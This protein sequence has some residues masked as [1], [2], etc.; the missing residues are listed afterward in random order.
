MLVVA[1]E[2]VVRL[3]VPLAEPHG[4]RNPVS[5]ISAADDTRS[6]KETPRSTRFARIMSHWR[7]TVSGW[8]GCPLRHVDYEA[9]DLAFVA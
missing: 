7:K 1:T 8:A 5:R 4:S 9:I 2:W 3:V 6:G